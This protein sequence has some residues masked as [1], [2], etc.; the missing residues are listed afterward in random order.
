MKTLLYIASDVRS[1]STVLDNLLS[2]HPSTE[3]VGELQ[4][5]SNHINKT[6]IGVS[7]G[8]ICTCGQSLDECRVWSRVKEIFEKETGR[9]FSDATTEVDKSCRSKSF[10][11]LMLLATLI[12]I[13][14]VRR[15]LINA[16][17][18]QRKLEAIGRDCFL[19]L[20][21]FSRITGAEIVIDSSK[22]A[23]QLQALIKTK[24]ANV[25]L[26][27]IHIVRDGRAV[28]YSKMKRAEQYKKY[29]ASFGMISA[30]RG[31]CYSNAKILNVQCYFQPKDVVTVRYEDLC[32]N[33]EATM[34]KICKSLGI[35]FEERM[36][37]LSSKNKHNIAG[38]SHRF[39]WNAETPIKL[40]ERWKSG[41]TGLQ[42]II[43]YA[44]ASYWHKRFGY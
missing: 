7:Y 34:K 21:I 20:D 18:D 33:R 31:W 24:P 5:L 29:G 37:C 10:H 43:Y 11:Y 17:Y 41:I 22:R 40:D 1:G 23:D 38:T 42:M 25:D 19:L 6:G 15:R 32:G 12:P 39:T 14:S 27:V 4:Y 16:A 26:K 9:A 2:N 36:L 44:I 8:W 28:V 3:T 13:S 35:S 30:V